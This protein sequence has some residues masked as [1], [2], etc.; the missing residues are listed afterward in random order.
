MH[1]CTMMGVEFGWMYTYI[2]TYTNISFH[3]RHTFFFSNLELWTYFQFSTKTR[4]ITL[5]SSYI[6]EGTEITSTWMWM[7]YKT[8]KIWKEPW[9]LAQVKWNN[10][11]EVFGKSFG[12]MKMDLTWT[13]WSL[14]SHGSYK[15]LSTNPPSRKNIH[16]HSREDFTAHFDLL[17]YLLYCFT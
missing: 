4:K 17:Q 8:W 9:H 7:Y 14:T 15:L 11:K 1:V 6:G 16:V 12:R 5:E 3:L 10:V 13:L 2:C